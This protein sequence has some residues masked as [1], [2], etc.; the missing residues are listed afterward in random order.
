MYIKDMFVYKV[1]QAD[2]RPPSATLWIYPSKAAGGKY[3]QGIFPVTITT[4]MDLS[5]MRTLS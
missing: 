4:L 3:W 1:Q 2:W 5:H